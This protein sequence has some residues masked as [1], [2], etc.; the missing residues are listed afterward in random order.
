MIRYYGG[1]EGSG[2]SCMM[3]RDLYRH[4][5]YGG[6]ILTFPGYEVYG[7]TK[8]QVISETI[9]PEQLLELITG[10]RSTIDVIRNQRIAVG[11]DEV[12]NFF[13]HHTWYN[14]INDVLKAILQQRRKLQIAFLMTGPIYEELPPDIRRM[15]HEVIH[16]CDGHTLKRDI[17]RG[18]TCI[19]YKQ[20]MRGLLSHPNYHYTRKMKFRMIPWQRHFD[21][22]A[23]IS[24]LNQFVK[25]RFQN[26]EVIVGIDGKPIESGNNELDFGSIDGLM[27]KYQPF[28]DPRRVNVHKILQHLIG[29]G[30]FTLEKS[31]LEEMMPGERLDGRTGIGTILKSLGARYKG[32]EKVYDL[33]AVSL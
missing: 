3:T 7:R 17:P 31:L 18:Q 24:P 8:K 6:R 29:K 23:A 4:A 22:Y 16:C 30:K 25:V 32:N 9:F 20:D 2:K 27:E 1:V 13:D 15:I 10:D 26:R 19:Y 33:S 14:K 5:L 21:T 12:S 28:E 11:V